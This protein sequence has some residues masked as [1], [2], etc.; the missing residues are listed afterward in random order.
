MKITV[1]TVKPFAPAAVEKIKETVEDAGYEFE[2]L[3]K[4]ENQSDFVKTAANTDAL[5]IRS[6]KATKEVI[7]AGGDRLKII[8]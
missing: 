7:E 8:A 4:Y 1:A 6:D 5:I 3:E 2:L